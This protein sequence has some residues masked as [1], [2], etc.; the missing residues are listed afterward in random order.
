MQ[1][2]LCSQLKK[3][4][5]LQENA[6][7]YVYGSLH[8]AAHQRVACC[9][10]ELLELQTRILL[11]EVSSVEGPG[12]TGQATE[13]SDLLADAAAQAAS[14]LPATPQEREQVIAVAAAQ[15]TAVA[16][17][18]VTLNVQFPDRDKD[19][20]QQSQQ[21]SPPDDQPIETVPG[22]GIDA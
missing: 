3:R 21:Q 1:R 20:Q 14:T 12:N 13:G 9:H 22:M 16:S 19:V 15:A 5:Q 6:L 18:R 10:G 2:R 7:A 11:G 17:E 4:V 8:A